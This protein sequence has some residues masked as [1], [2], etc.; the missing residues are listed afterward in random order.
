MLK[1]KRNLVLDIFDYAEHKQCSLYDQTSDAKGQAYD[2]FVTEERNGWKELSFSLPQLIDDGDNFRLSFIREGYKI[3]LIDDDGTDWYILS[4]SKVTHNNFTKSVS[5]TAGHVAQLLKHK[6]LDLE[7][8]DEEGNNVGTAAMLLTTILEGTGWEPGHVDKFK[9]KNNVDI[10]YRSMKAPVKT[11]AFKLIANMCD[12]FEAKPIYHGDD[13]TVDI[14]PLNPFSEP[15]NGGL[16]NV[17]N[18]DVIELHYGTNVSNVTRVLNEENMITR[19]YAYGA[20]GDKTNGY[21][22]IDEC[23]HHVYKLVVGTGVHGGAECQMNLTDANGINIVRYFKAGQANVDYPIVGQAETGDN[24]LANDTEISTVYWS[25]LDPVSRMYVW[26]P[27]RETA[28]LLYENLQGSQIAA[29]FT[30]DESARQEVTNW[31]SSLMD[32]HYYQNIGLLTNHM[33]QTIAKYQQEAPTY[34]KIVNDKAAEYAE[35]STALSEVIGSVDFCK[36]VCTIDKPVNGYVR[37]LLNT[38]EAPKGVAFRTDYD[39]KEDK[40]F[41]W[42]VADKLKEN[43]DPVHNGASIVYICYET[44]DGAPYMFDKA[45]LKEIDDEDDPHVLTLWLPSSDCKYTR[46]STRVYLFGQYNIN[47]LLG[48]YESSVES[49]E[50]VL[51]SSVKNVTVNHPTFYEKERPSCS[52]TVLNGYGWWWKWYEGNTQESELYFCWNAMGD[53][54]WLPVTVS[55]ADAIS[56]EGAYWFNWKKSVLYRKESGAW[57]A[58]NETSADKRLSALFGTVYASFLSMD[59]YQKGL[60]QTYTLT[61]AVTVPA[62]NYAFE[63]GYGGYWVFTTTAD[64][65]STDSL[66]YDSTLSTVTQ[67]VDGVDT[68]LETKAYR[69]DNVN[70]HSGDIAKDTSYERGTINN[71]GGEED[72]ATE[73]R[74]GY[75]RAYPN[76]EYLYN[77]NGNLKI[78]YYDENRT[79]LALDRVSTLG[80]KRTSPD[81]TR[82]IR[83]VKPENNLLPSINTP[84]YNNK[85]I[86][87]EDETY[88]VLYGTVGSGELKGVI[89]LTRKFADLAD[90][91]YEVL[92][93]ALQAAQAEVTELERSMTESLGDLYREGYWQKNDYVDGDEKKLYDDALDNLEKLSEPEATYNITYLD[94][95]SADYDNQYNGAALDSPK[96]MWPDIST[97]KAAHLIDPDVGINTWAFVDK[98]EKC[99]DQPWK[100]KISI[101]TNLTTISQHSFTDV[102]THIAEV[103]GEAKGKM[104]M[105]ERAAAITENGQLA[106][107]RLEGKIDANKL[108]ITGGSSTW[109]TD[110]NGNMVFVSADGNGAMTLTGNGFSIANSKDEWGDW[111]WRSFG[112]GEGFTAD[113]IVA[114]Y[115][116]AERILAGS[117]TTSHLDAGVGAELDITANKSLRLIVNNLLE[118]VDGRIDEAML[119]ITQE[120]IVAKVTSSETFQ[121]QYATREENDSKFVGKDDLDDLVGYRIE[122]SSTSDFLSNRI[123]TITLTAHV[124]HGS[125]EIT[126]DDSR[127][128]WRRNMTGDSADTQW[129][130]T[131]RTLTVGRNDV[132]YGATY[133]C[134]LMPEEE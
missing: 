104:S 32:F 25:D 109:Y 63:N 95:Y 92:L 93:P 105:Y 41:K 120:G 1:R 94:L 44:L 46:Q 22:G 82:Y 60:H 49:I 8:S 47:G 73:Y 35:S 124:Y 91:T 106:A 43:G 112:T 39:K 110:D 56:Q 77:Y 88:T 103:T 113:E 90:E 2:V 80:E 70:Y 52:P 54:T 29:F 98:V 3:R 18:D 12:L 81:N 51:S 13:K 15:K 28:Y 99:Y 75:M 21:C 38:E 55:D 96:T 53:T 131:G 27:V 118:N 122:V 111:N 117:I 121:S 14:V 123:P 74:S 133:I 45:Y 69:F 5:V 17:V 114:G 11:G 24:A 33:L 19:L 100:T 83:V 128:V 40:Q 58:K 108:L 65:K 97:K 57:V 16:P 10:K 7:F 130:H 84:D 116:S 4:E 68:I 102:M 126:V 61:P 30:E 23:T 76:T 62:G 66:A 36:L 85:I 107:E 72:S 26:D 9:E 64:V 37:L 71:Q 34:M 115:L 20:Y 42:R 132:A 89:P 67:T 59:K 127:L 134:E 87:K 86:T 125:T 101:N 31:F 129:S 119:E 78:F 48:A 6:K 50:T 79:Y